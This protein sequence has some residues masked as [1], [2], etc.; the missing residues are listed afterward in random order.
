[1]H[2]ESARAWAQADSEEYCKLIGV[3]QGVSSTSSDAQTV[4]TAFCAMEQPAGSL[5]SEV[6]L[7]TQTPA[8]VSPLVQLQSVA[9]AGKHPSRAP[10]ITCSPIQAMAA[11]LTTPAAGES[12]HNDAAL[13]CDGNTHVQAVGSVPDASQQRLNGG[14]L[15]TGTRPAAAAMEEAAAATEEVAA[16]D[17]AAIATDEAAAPDAAAAATDGAATPEAAATAAVREE[18]AAPEA[19][20]AATDE[21]AAFEVAAAATNKAAAAGAAAPEVAFASTGEAAAPEAAP[22]ATNEAATPEAASTVAAASQIVPDTEDE[23]RSA[24]QQTSSESQRASPSSLVQLTAVDSRTA[25]LGVEVALMWSIPQT[26]TPF[27]CI[28]LHIHIYIHAACEYIYL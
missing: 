25:P 1:M 28:M 4:D 9:S 12:R 15:A 5:M 27:R 13:R 2:C 6:S 26:S 23:V 14:G 16:P 8:A 24:V 17:S 22:A 10:A 18:G 19:G 11:A 20:A 7:A 21:A 3:A